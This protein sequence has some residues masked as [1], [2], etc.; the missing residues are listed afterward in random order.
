VVVNPVNPLSLSAKPRD[1]VRD[2]PVGTPVLTTDAL[3]AIARETLNTFT[4]DL[5]SV[6]IA[7][8]VTSIARVSRNR[9][10]LTNDGSDFTVRLVA[11]DGVRGGVELWLNTVDPV[12]LREGITYL[13]GLARTQSGDPARFVTTYRQPV[14]GP[15]TTWFDRTAAALNDGSASAL[16]PTLVNP[17]LDA[18]FHAAAF[19]GLWAR[20]MVYADT[21]GTLVAGRE[22]DMEFTVTGRT[23]ENRASGWAGQAVRDWNKLDLGTVAQDAVRLTRLATQPVKFEPGRYTAILGRPALAQLVRRITY[24]FDGTVPLSQFFDPKTQ[25][26]KLGQRVMDERIT[27]R[28]D[29]N[30]P[31]GGYLPFSSDGR[32]CTAGIWVE[33]GALK[34]LP[35]GAGA[36]IDLGVAPP[37]Q[38]PDSLR[39]E[40]ATPI[41]ID[42][43]IA[44]CKRGIYVNRFANIELLDIPT[45][46]MTGVTSGGCYLIRDGKIDKAIKDLRF[47]ESPFFALNRVEAVGHTAR[48]AFGYAPWQGDWPIAPTIVPPLMVRDFNFIALAEAI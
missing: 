11:S 4:T 2:T 16:I 26:P 7:Q 42:D 25:R 10:R 39:I 34:A 40:G 45:G 48:A 43:M 36:A 31:D 8:V 1:T 15:N 23:P 22:T 21:F 6:S 32:V 18:G 28:S 24:A 46:Q 20:S 5:A 19:A 12:R 38:P 3:T 33:R 27:I 13:E 30:D 9:V 47:L 37:N 17:V 44:Q 35:Y 14:Y 29:P 41:T